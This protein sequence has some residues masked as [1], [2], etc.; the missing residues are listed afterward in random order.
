VRKK[1]TETFLPWVF[2]GTADRNENPTEIPCDF[3]I[4]SEISSKLQQLQE[5]VIWAEKSN[6]LLGGVF[7]YP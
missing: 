1:D 2:H 6:H 7:L 3:I 4:K 5:H